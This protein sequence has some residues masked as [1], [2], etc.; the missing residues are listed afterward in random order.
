[1][2]EL[3]DY[4][5]RALGSVLKAARLRLG[6]TQAEAGKQAKIAR[7][8]IA[9]IERGSKV[10]S[11]AVF[12]GY[13]AAMGVNPGDMLVESHLAAPAEQGIHPILLEGVR[14]LD[15]DTQSRLAASWHHF[16]H[17][18]TSC[19]SAKDAHPPDG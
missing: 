1:V 3:T 19:L 8:Y 2:E 11:L 9:H 15:S 13:C 18:V 5:K 7:A 4:Q 16:E 17:F 6:W 14:R 12:I 10:P